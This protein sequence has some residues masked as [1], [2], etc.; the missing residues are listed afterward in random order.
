MSVGARALRGGVERGENH[1][2]K[3]SREKLARSR[4]H[5][6]RACALA[7]ALSRSRGAC[8]Y[9]LG[10]VGLTMF[11]TCFGVECALLL[12]PLFANWWSSKITIDLMAL[13]DA[14]FAV[15]VAISA[16]LDK[17]CDTSCNCTSS[18]TGRTFV[19]LEY[20]QVTQLFR[21]VIIIL[22]FCGPATWAHRI[23]RLYLFI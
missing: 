4:A 20:L 17:G 16:I 3:S 15:A 22:R 7:L 21:R 18:G 19:G 10:A 23:E 11:V 6:S 12:E 2:R 9:G 1:R 13:L 8:R 5:A 14:N